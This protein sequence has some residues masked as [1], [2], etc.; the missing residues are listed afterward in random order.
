MN[1]SKYFAPDEFERCSPSCN[2]NDMD[3]G[4]LDVMDNIREKAGCPLTIN[5]AYRSPEWDR[6]KGRSGTG[7]HTTGKA[8]DFRATSSSAK[9]TIV[10]A[11]LAC[12]I[13]RIGVGATFVHI[14]TSTNKGHVQDLLWTY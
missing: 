7:P 8:V 3:Q 2:I 12:G 14:D 11:A 10:K 6:S 13:R 5:S 1:T 4:F 9:M